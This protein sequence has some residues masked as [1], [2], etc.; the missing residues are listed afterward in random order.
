[1]LVYVHVITK[2]VIFVAFTS[3]EYHCALIRNNDDSRDF[4]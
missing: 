4:I 1:M 2:T 3:L